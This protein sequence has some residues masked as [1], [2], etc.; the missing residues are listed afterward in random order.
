MG[1]EDES[2][3][4]IPDKYG[5]FYPLELDRF[6]FLKEAGK[7]NKQKC[8]LDETDP[9]YTLHDIRESDAFI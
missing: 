3:D 2:Y 8:E 6:D 5:E 7:Y 1:S 9:R 4:G